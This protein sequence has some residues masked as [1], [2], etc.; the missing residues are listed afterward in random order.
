MASPSW[1]QRLRHNK[2]LILLVAAIMVVATL[3]LALGLGLGLG[4]PHRVWASKS[5]PS[6]AN[7]NTN[8]TTGDIIQPAVGT[9]WDY[10]LGFDLT[11][12]SA[13]PA[14]STKF[15]S[16]DLENTSNSTTAALQA[17]GHTIACYFSAG[18][19]ESYRTDTVSLPSSAIGNALDGWPDE[20]WLD[21][22]TSPVRD[23][24]VSRIIAAAD[25][26]CA[27]VDADNIDAYDN[28][29]GFDLTQDDA[30]AY[31]QFLAAAAHAAGLA[32][33]LKNGGDIVGQ[34]VDVAQWVI[35]EQCVEYD[36][37]GLY[38]PFVDAGKPVF[39]VEYTQVED[40]DEVGDGLMESDCGAGGQE[41]FSSIIKHESLDDWVVRC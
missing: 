11:T 41:G 2:K 31:V 18:S 27:G 24:M 8:A 15:Y 5:A 22:R 23:L 13:A 25:K 32:F 20:H 6:N 36:E 16:T 7:T 38:A 21:V 9:T 26:G 3:A 33:G 19:T 35:V 40:T 29:S 17:A 39:H 28:D 37:C 10:P 1:R 34:V 4:L 14:S 30:V 12:S